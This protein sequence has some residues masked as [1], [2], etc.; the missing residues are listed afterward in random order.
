DGA[1]QRVGLRAAPL[2]QENDG[3]RDLAFAQIAADG[4]AKRRL[5]GRV[6]EEIVD[7]LKGDAEIEPEVSQRLFLFL[8]DTAQHSADLGAAAEQVRALAA[9]D[10]EVLLS[11][12]VH[13]PGL[14]ELIELP[15]DHA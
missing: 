9:N 11:A 14:G 6:I 8:A 10:F 13:V 12:D 15:F 7:Q 4:L 1:N 2:Q 5:V 3:Q